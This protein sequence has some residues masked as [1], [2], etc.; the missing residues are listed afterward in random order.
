M[1]RDPYVSRI[2]PVLEVPKDAREIPGFP[3]YVITRRGEIFS[4]WRI[5]RGGPGS[6][7]GALG[8]EIC[9][10]PKR[11]AGRFRNGLKCVDL[12]HGDVHKTKSVEALLDEVFQR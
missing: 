11:V 7:G 6:K 2:L 8:V 1:S 9:D 10:V 4:Y 5:I 3:G 12:R